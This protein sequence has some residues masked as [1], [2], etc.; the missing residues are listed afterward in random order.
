MSISTSTKF[1]NKSYTCEENNRYCN[2]YRDTHKEKFNT[3]MREY[4]K[5][6][7]CSEEYKE[8]LY[9]YQRLRW[10]KSNIAKLE[11]MDV[12]TKRQS[13]RLAKLKK[14]QTDLLENQSSNSE[15]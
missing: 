15:E 2:K 8:K 6:K 9:K 1:Y 12:L 3:Y 14:L 5:N 7:R 11:E 4:A 13:E 10:Y